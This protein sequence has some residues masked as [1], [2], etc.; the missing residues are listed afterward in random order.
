MFSGE[1]QVTHSRI[2]GRCCPLFGVEF[3]WVKL[4]AEVPI[5]LLVIFIADRAV[6]LDP[7]LRTYR[8]R[9]DDTCLSID[10]PM[11]DHS[12]LEVPPCFEFFAHERV[13]RPLIFRGS[14][15]H[16]LT[17]GGSDEDNTECCRGK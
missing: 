11:N 5:P 7:V 2:F 1:H 3:H 16:L 4:F 10:S 14:R 12:E 6:A 15:V 9:F 17:P 13:I 8:P